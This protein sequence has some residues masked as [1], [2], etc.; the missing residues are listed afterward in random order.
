MFWPEGLMLSS[1]VCVHYYNADARRT[2]FFESQAA[3]S[4]RDYDALILPDAQSTTT[5]IIM[6]LVKTTRE[7]K[8]NVLCDET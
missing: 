5:T 1:F 3:S 7:R 8:R 2:P 6:K 4:Q